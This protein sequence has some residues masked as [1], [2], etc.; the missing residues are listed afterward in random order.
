MS[1]HSRQ[2]VCVCVCVCVTVSLI[3]WQPMLL[4][5]SIMLMTLFNC[6]AYQSDIGT[7]NENYYFY[8]QQTVK[9]Y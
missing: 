6:G 2:R 3:E 7:S 4:L 9:C 1:Y 8:S 5:L